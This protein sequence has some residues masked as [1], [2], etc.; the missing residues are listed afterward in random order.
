MAVLILKLSGPLQSWGTGLK[1]RD[2]E[3]DS[4]PSKS[5]VIGMIAGAMGRRRDEDISDLASLRFGAREDRPGTILRDFHTAHIWNRKKEDVSYIGYRYY[6]QDACFVVGLEGDD[7]L[8]NRCAYALC[9]PVFPPYLGRRACVPDVGLVKGL[10]DGTLE[11]VLSVF[12]RQTGGN[13]WDKKDRVVSEDGGSMRLSVETNEIGSRAR[14]DEPLSFDFHNRR[15]G[16]RMEKDM[17]TTH[18]LGADA[19]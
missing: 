4:M 3:T 7:D 14:K 8:L 13:E 17:S 2:H 18:R 19:P 10:F 1:L 11:D 9:H 6:L 16:Y 5:G 12:P 15:Y